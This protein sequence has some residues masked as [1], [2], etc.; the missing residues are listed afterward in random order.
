[1]KINF[2]NFSTD[3]G[4]DRIGLENLDM[5]CLGFSEI[6]K[7]AKINYH[8]FFGDNKVNYGDF[9]QIL[10]AQNVKERYTLTH[11]VQFIAPYKYFTSNSPQQKQT[12]LNDSLSTYQPIYSLK[13]L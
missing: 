13:T 12:S 4:G 10:K 3:I 6:D 5:N 1:M 9:V 7:D 2:L 8:E 11:R